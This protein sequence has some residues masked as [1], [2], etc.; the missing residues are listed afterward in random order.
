MK[1]NGT[2]AESGMIARAH[3]HFMANTGKF[4]PSVFANSLEDI[5][6]LRIDRNQ[7][8]DNIHTKFLNN[9][10]LG[11]EKNTAWENSEGKAK[12]PLLIAA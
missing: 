1:G 8:S 4:N 10:K 6:S 7:K 12:K 3:P 11:I 2:E 5:N 9:P